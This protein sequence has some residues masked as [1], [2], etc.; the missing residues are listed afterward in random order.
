ML[1][2]H[3]RLPSSAGRKTIVFQ[4]MLWRIRNHCNVTLSTKCQKQI[5]RFDT[6]NRG[7]MA[8][9]QLYGDWRS[10]RCLRISEPGNQ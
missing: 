6:K 10:E 5:N 7:H 3:F 2:N 9:N 8:V 1:F 4:R